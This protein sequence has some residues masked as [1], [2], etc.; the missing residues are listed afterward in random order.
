MAKSTAARPSNST[1]TFVSC[2]DGTGNKFSGLLD[3]NENFH[4]H[5]PGIGTYIVA[6]SESSRFDR[7][8][9][10]YMKA[11][12][13]AIATSL[14]DHVLGG[15]RFLMRYYTPG[16]D[17]FLF[18]FS[19]GAYTARFLAEMLDQV[20]LLSAGNDEMCHFAWKTETFSRPVKPI[21][22]LGL[23]DTMQRN[24]FPYTAR[25]SA[26]IIRHVVSIEECRAKFRQDLISQDRSNESNRYKHRG[27]PAK[28]RLGSS[29][30]EHGSL[31]VGGQPSLSTPNDHRETLAVPV[32]TR[33]AS[34]A[35]MGSYTGEAT[36]A[37]PSV[38]DISLQ[39]TQNRQYS[40]PNYED[41][42]DIREVRFAGCHIDIGR[43]WPLH[44]GEDAALSH[45][46]LVWMVREA[47]R[48]G[49]QLDETKL[50]AL[51]C[52]YTEMLPELPPLKPHIEEILA[53]VSTIDL[54][55]ASPATVVIGHHDGSADSEEAINRTDHLDRQLPNPSAP[56][57]QYN[58]KF[59]Q[60]LHFAATCGRIYDV[61]QF[62]NGAS[63]FEI[64][65]WNV[66]EYLPF[67][68]MDLQEDGS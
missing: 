27:R 26:R 3:C 43:R 10:W 42:Q 68:C 21:R 7:L 64:I 58:T 63:R 38:Y 62:D 56:P 52:D 29:E 34:Q 23:F 4:Y 50:E 49:L 2:F 45:V 37:T 11:K 65:S 59:L 39:A 31:V 28:V 17:I 46:P 35:P 20:G 24:Q 8:K 30:G 60:H 44:P 12:D 41:E 14:A 22:I 33:N 15:Y 13:M 25:S 40:D 66:M 54:D 61:L 6:T 5:Q 32:E 9:R 67:R 1:K 16:D 55:S 48:A 18:G 57:H 51:H 36:R 53:S 19:R 47:Q